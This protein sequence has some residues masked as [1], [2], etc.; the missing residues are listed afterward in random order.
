MWWP[1]LY[2]IT[3]L[4]FILVALYYL[5]IPMPAEIGDRRHVIISDMFMRVVWEY[6]SEVVEYFFGPK[7]RVKYF[8]LVLIGIFSFFRPDLS[9]VTVS[10]GN[11]FLIFFHIWHSH[12]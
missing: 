5:Y 11:P 8:R 10:N 4:L 2:W 7:I 6:P 3:A 12:E 9:D 1:L